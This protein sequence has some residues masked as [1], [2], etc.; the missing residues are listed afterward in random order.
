MKLK[1]FLALVFSLSLLVTSLCACG[2]A[3]QNGGNDEMK[4][5]AI[6]AKVSHTLSGNL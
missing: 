3:E 4:T 1:K 6:I 5:I 2:T